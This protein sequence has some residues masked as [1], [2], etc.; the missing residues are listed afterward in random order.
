M[1]IPVETIH[2]AAAEADD[3]LTFAAVYAAD[4]IA[5]VS[6]VRPHVTPRSNPEGFYT[7]RV[8]RRDGLPADSYTITSDEASL[9]ISS[10]SRRGLLFGIGRFLRLSPFRDDCLDIPADLDLQFSPSS[11]IRGYQIGYGHLS[12]SMDS[13]SVAQFDRYIRDLVLFGCNAI[14]I[15]YKPDPSP[16]HKL[17]FDEMTAELSILAARYDLDCTVWI[18]NWEDEAYYLDTVASGRELEDRGRF[19]H[20]LPKISAIT[21]PGGDPGKLS[22][23]VLFPW[24]QRLTE[25]L[26]SSGHP[27]L[28]W[29]SAQW[30]RADT[31]WYD[32]FS[33]QA[34]RNPGWLAG[35]VHGPWTQ[36]SIPELRARLRSDLPIRRYDDLTHGI[37]CQYPIPDWDLAHAMTSGRESINPRPKAYKH[38]H[39]L[40][41]RDTVGSTPHTTGINA[42]INTFVWLDQEW[43][44]DTAPR[45]TLKDY[46]RIFLS[47]DLEDE[48]AD[49]ALALEENWE[50][51]LAANESVEETL[52]RWK[53]LE[54]S[55]DPDVNAHW[56]FQ[57]PL[58]RV[59]YDA[60]VRR[61]L[62]RERR[63]A[64][65]AVEELSSD[66]SREAVHRALTWLEER[67][68]DSIEIELREKC[69]NL[70]KSLFRS[71]GLK[72]S[73]DEHGAAQKGRGAFMDAIDEPLN[74]SRW[75]INH[76]EEA[77]AAESPSERWSRVGAILD[78]SDSGYGGIYDNLGTHEQI[79]RLV[80]PVDVSEDPGG[81]AGSRSAFGIALEGMLRSQTVEIKSHDGYP[82]PKAWLTC[83]ESIY[84]TPLIL[85]YDGLE[86]G[87]AYTLRIVYSSRI[88]KLAKLVANDHVVHD[89]IATGDE[90][91]KKFEIPAGVVR[92]GK[93]E[94]R[95]TGGG[96]RG[97]Q[98]AELWI[99]PKH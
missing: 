94:L 99:T 41:H 12:N 61:R 34:N 44:P 18:P 54:Q 40:Y 58:L 32:A 37:F 9:T 26:A 48:F 6:G 70:S 30:M 78:R 11:R 50:G 49:G 13:W 79:G 28:A 51:A 65:R 69:V 84:D 89:L 92:D 85:A 23:D 59:Y 60:S 8:D 96:E 53:Q 62:V 2:I 72:S 73:V 16:H 47:T 14:E 45:D 66:R 98:V 35:I 71:V 91:L 4:E 1:Q 74:D 83:V 82:I 22:P 15:E 76:L 3:D 43:D 80:N 67:T 21:V 95:W 24:V 31:A 17:P 10:S 75:L 36:L 25:T 39:N 93:L 63:T 86:D 88:G 29:V 46:T 97:V 68:T 64:E 42:D 20:I 77:L 33:R 55:A 90:P 52:D 57:C 38:I 5:Y 56:R 87:S 7:L 81:L 19:F 27:P